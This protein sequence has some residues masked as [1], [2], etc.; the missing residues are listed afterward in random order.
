MPIIDRLRLG[1]SSQASQEQALLD[2]EIGRLEDRRGR[3]PLALAA[4]RRA[5]EIYER[6]AQDDPGYR[7]GI[8]MCHHVIGNLHCDQEQWSD[9]VASFSP[10]R[11]W[12]G[13]AVTFEDPNATD[14]LE[15]T[16]HNLA[17]ALAKQAES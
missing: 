14:D 9:A 12:C 5:P 8:A 13:L 7:E 10:R 17:E 11:A 2:V 1:P 6:L 15:G 16:R 3:F 4:F